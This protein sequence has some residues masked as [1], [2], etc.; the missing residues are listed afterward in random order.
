M[1]MSPNSCSLSIPSLPMASGGEAWAQAGPSQPP[2]GSRLPEVQQPATS[3]P[4]HCLFPS[5]IKTPFGKISTNLCKL[6]SH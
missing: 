5:P 4:T 6:I 1:S 2:P 3:R